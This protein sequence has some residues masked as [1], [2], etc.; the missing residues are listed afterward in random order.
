MLTETSVLAR[1]KHHEVGLGKVKDSMEGGGYKTYKDLIKARGIATSIPDL[2][3]AI[4]SDVK[5]I[6][7]V[8]PLVRQVAYCRVR[9]WM[10]CIP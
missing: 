5:I 9:R 1:G 7:K 3:V 8:C 2:L 6:K 4:I 10:C